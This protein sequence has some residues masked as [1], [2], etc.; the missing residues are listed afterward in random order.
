M[1]QL[2]HVKTN[3]PLELLPL[4]KPKLHLKHHNFSNY[5]EHQH[6]NKKGW[7]QDLNKIENGKS[8]LEKLIGIRFISCW[9][10]SHERFTSLC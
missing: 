1:L 2:W 4:M 8:F 10:Q 5:N 3:K 9:P 7:R 6:I